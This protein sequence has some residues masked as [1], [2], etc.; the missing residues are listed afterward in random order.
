MDTVYIRAHLNSIDE[1]LLT[2]SS[3]FEDSEVEDDVNGEVESI[4][5]HINAIKKE[6]L[7]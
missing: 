3:A 5:N 2:L 4:E 1:H 7:K 6:L